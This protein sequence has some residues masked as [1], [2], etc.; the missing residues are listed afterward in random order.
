MKPTTR[1]NLEHLRTI[2]LL[3]TGEKL[4]TYNSLRIYQA[5]WYNM[6]SRWWTKD[7]KDETINYLKSLYEKVDDEVSLFLKSTDDKN[8][9]PNI[10][11]LINY[12]EVVRKSIDG[13][14]NL[15]ITYK[16][17]PHIVA[18]ISGIVNDMAMLTY[19]RLM[20]SIPAEMLTPLLKEDLLF[21]QDIIFK[22]VKK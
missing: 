8:I 22:Y 4:E 14:Y 17:Y 1:D 16:N 12:T 19:C 9:T 3:K 7:G 10:Q 2:S 20:E 15:S 11:I 18:Q 21:G 6:I 5:S 13:L